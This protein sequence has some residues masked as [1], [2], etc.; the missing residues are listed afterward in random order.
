MSLDQ[1][2]SAILRALTKTSSCISVEELMKFAH[3]S[4]RTIY[5]D[6]KKINSWLQETGLY[7][8]QY[9]RGAGYFLDEETKRSVEK[10]EIISSYDYSPRE[11]VAWTAIIIF[12]REKEIYL[13]DLMTY[14]KVSRNTMFDDVK[15]LKK[16]LSEFQ[17]ELRAS[18]VTG[19]I[20]RGEEEQK[21]K[22]LSCFLQ[23][24]IVKEG[25]EGFEGKLAHYAPSFLEELTTMFAL[26]IKSEQELSLKFTD[27]VLY[28]LSVNTLLFLKRMKRGKWIKIDSVEK[29][30]LKETKEFQSAKT[31]AEKLS[32]K[33]GILF[34][35][36]E[37]YYLTTHL[38]GSKVND[39][40]THNLEEK[41]FSFF[42]TIV[43]SM[44]TDFQ[45]YACVMFRNEKEVEHNLLIHLRPAFYRVKY[46]L[47]VDNPLSHTIQSTYKDVYNITKK[48]VHH[49]EK[50][51]HNKMSE[52]EIAYIA[53]HFGGWMRKEGTVPAKRKKA[54]I[55]CASGVGTSRM[56][57]T[58]LYSLFSTVDFQTT[59]SLR[60][61]ET[62]PLHVDFIVSTVS[63][64]NRGCPVFL[65]NP[66][67]TEGEKASLLKKVSTII[68]DGHVLSH[69]VEG[70]MDLIREHAK[71]QDEKLLYQKLKEHL[72]QPTLHGKGE[73]SKPVLSDL[74][75]KENINL[76][77][78][79]SSWQEAVRHASIPLLENGDIQEEYIKAMIKNVEELGPYIVITTDVAIPHAR[80][81]QGVNKLSMS[82]MTLSKPVSFSDKDRH[83]VQLVI[84]LAAIDNETHLK[85]LSQLTTLLSEREN[86]EKMINTDS[87]EEVIDLITKY[88]K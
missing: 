82:L 62:M 28:M 71:I 59:V 2:S 21:R 23:E 72:Y 51:A 20:I 35:E 85:A 66:I 34:Q 3:V 47:P 43:S 11:R 53:I 9:V 73:R 52:D 29:N 86:V 70:I 68:E 74:L 54:L 55:V 50:E 77:E 87:K 84:V 32:K 57:E 38:L 79:P 36:D 24:I 88:S 45:K 76:K 27:D 63:I 7:P 42:R 31:I 22:S 26:F 75:I 1:R 67:L 65:V 8:L 46:G 83:R 5:Y 18:K 58:Q 30:V 49:V 80:P 44:V 19:Y 61:Y 56:L 15:K 39:F 60:E 78:S 13:H 81:E 4:K 25:R 16:I 6:V 64:P 17:L 69:S 33:W 40:T 48:V 12:I 10:E 37:V 14:L 41:D